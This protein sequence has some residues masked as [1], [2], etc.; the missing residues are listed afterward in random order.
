RRVARRRPHRGA[1]GLIVGRGLLCI[2][3]G[4]A[5]GLEGN[6][7]VA[8]RWLGVAGVVA[9]GILAGADQ[10]IGQPAG[11]LVDIEIVL[12]VDVSQSMDYDEHALQKGGY[13]EAFRNK[14]VINA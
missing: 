5:A 6:M 7:R 14:D 11:K 3:L 13:V 12:A 2:T 9:L 10:S 1:G 8:S 4:D